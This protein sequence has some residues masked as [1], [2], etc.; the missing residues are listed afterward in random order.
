MLGRVKGV[1]NGT[2]GLGWAAFGTSSSDSILSVLG[3]SFL[4][5]AQ[6]L[7]CTDGLSLEVGVVASLEG[8]QGHVL[9]ALSSSQFIS[10]VSGIA[11]FKKRESGT[12]SSRYLENKGCRSYL[13]QVLWVVVDLVNHLLTESIVVVANSLRRSG[14]GNSGQS[15]NNSALHGDIC[16]SILKTSR[17]S[18]HS[19]EQK[20]ER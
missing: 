10:Q 11:C 18:V 17:F 19:L 14:K 3:R 8:S 12:D 1:W 15:K 7:R 5:T 9:R 13:P 2:G 20:K 16:S 6:D 4:D